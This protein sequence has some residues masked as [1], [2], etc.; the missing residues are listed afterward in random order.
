MTAEE[1]G[2]WMCAY[3]IALLGRTVT[4]HGGYGTVA[5]EHNSDH[6]YTASVHPSSGGIDIRAFTTA[7]APADVATECSSLAAHGPAAPVC[8]SGDTG[9]C[10]HITLVTASELRQE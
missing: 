3:A 9:M 5:V 4:F 8:S 6:S 1:N 7:V 2:S 10:G